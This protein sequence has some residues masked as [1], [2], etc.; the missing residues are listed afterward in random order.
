[1]AAQS[2][3][4]LEAKDYAT[5]QKSAAEATRLDP[6]FEEAWV[7]YGMA[8]ARLGQADQAREAYQRALALHDTRLRQ[9]TPQASQVFYEIFL[10]SLLG[11]AD[12]AES[13]LQRARAIFPDD[14]QI[15]ILASHWTEFQR[16]WEGWTVKPQ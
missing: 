16:L 9:G 12:A 3:A 15:S 5:A 13:L 2:A 7:G 11:H 6:Q 10:L 4:A 1:L 8:S 14:P